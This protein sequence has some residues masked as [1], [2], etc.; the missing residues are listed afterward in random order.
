MEDVHDI[1]R[2]FTASWRTL[3]T[4]CYDSDLISKTLPAL[5]A[6][7]ANELLSCGTY[8][9]VLHPQ[10][11]DIVGAGGWTLAHPIDTGTDYPHVRH[12][13]THPDYLRQ[14]IAKTIWEQCWSDIVQQQSGS[15]ATTVEVLSTIAAKPYYERLGF[16]FEKEMGV[17]VDEKTD[18][19]C[20]YM[21]RKPKPE[22]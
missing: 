22:I 6:V 9:V 13:A 4:D 21:V 3:L 14:G 11:K 18:L 12:V 7:R 1:N 17:P 2:L 15:S 10:S 16:K 19:P 8:Y 20:L 5:E